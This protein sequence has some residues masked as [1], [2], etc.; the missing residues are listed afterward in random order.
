MVTSHT[1]LLSCA[2]A[3]ALLVSALAASNVS[4]ASAA[5]NLVP[6]PAPSYSATIT[7]TDHGIPHITAN[8]FGSLGF[9]AGYAAAQTSG[10]TLADVLLPARAQRSRYL[11]PDGKYDDGV[12]MNGTNLQVDALVTDLH[13]RH[14]V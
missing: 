6:T 2:A 8:N 11:G 12:A 7:R 5:P 4:S 10:C 3:G 14:V 9:G 13:N 1:R